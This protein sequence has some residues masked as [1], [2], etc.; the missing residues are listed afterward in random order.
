VS[1]SAAEG[2]GIEVCP[3]A[4]VGFGDGKSKAGV[5]ISVVASGDEKEAGVEAWNVASRSGV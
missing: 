3:E 2:N 1:P 5:V 4:E